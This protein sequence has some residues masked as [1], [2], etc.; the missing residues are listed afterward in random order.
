LGWT[1]TIQATPDNLVESDSFGVGSPSIRHRSMKC[2][3]EAA[4]SVVVTPRHLAAN[5]PGVLLSG[6]G[7]ERIWRLA[8]GGYC[9]LYQGSGLKIVSTW[10]PTCAA[11]GVRMPRQP[12]R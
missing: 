2:S 12:P 10:P 7:D 11:D 5:A 1:E 4:F 3:W 8:V 9:V 6:T